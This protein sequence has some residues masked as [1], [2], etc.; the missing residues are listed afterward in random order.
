MT[1]GVY[2]V[3]APSGSGKTTLVERLLREVPRLRFSISCTTRQPRGNE[4]HGREYFFV[5]RDE[6]HQMIARQE[7]LEW[8][9]VF[10]NYYGTS[11]RFLEEAREAN[12]D[13][14]LDID[15]QGARQV[16]EKLPE[17]VSIFIL[18][19]SRQV[20]E[21]RLRSR[22]QDSEEVIAKRLE[23]A[24]REIHGY[25]RYDYV[26]INEELDR[27]ANCLRDIVLAE[28]WR[29]NGRLTGEEP[30]ESMETIREIA[31]S[32]RTERVHDQVQPILQSFGG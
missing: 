28:R 18:P 31:E 10:G 4:Q 26:L 27:S 22:S 1:T 7:L 8:A 14:L 19:P 5:T 23:D 11:R 21:H 32:C 3:S 2:I 13:L 16:K 17:A 25:I 9:E 29:R 6:F 12:T 24:R 20:L 30:A 15:I